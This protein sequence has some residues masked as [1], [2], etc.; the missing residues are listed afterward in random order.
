MAAGAPDVLTYFTTHGV[1]SAT[2]CPYQS[3]S[4]DTGVAPYWPLNSGWQNR[5]WMTTSNL[6]DFTTSTT[7][8]DE[9]LPEDDGAAGSRHLGFQRFVHL[10][11]GHDSELPRRRIAR[12]LT[13]RCRWSV[14]CDDST[15]PTGGY[16]II[17]NSW[18]Y[19]DNTIGDYGNNGYYIIPYGDIEIHNDISAIT[20][21]AYYTGAMA[22]VTWGG[23]NGNLVERRG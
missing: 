8:H 16:W 19:S 12:P 14:M 5:V 9:E 7:S 20:G 18:G 1:V 17:K 10:G 23:G 2:E 4:P 15:T 6:N 3:S 13:T 21:A 22:T 11:G